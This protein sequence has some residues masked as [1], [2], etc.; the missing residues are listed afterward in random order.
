MTMSEISYRREI[1]RRFPEVDAEAP[2]PVLLRQ[3]AIELFYTASP[4]FD[5]LAA[6]TRRQMN[7]L[8]EGGVIRF[9]DKGESTCS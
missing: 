4:L 1:A 9:E 3:V 6:E 5:Q 2:A 7:Y 8:R